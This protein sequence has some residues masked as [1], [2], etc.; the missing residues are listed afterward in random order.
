MR[1]IKGHSIQEKEK[2]K[3]KTNPG[4]E[5]SSNICIRL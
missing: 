4:K 1:S 2:K 3:T 5:T